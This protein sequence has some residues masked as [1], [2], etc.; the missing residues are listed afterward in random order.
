MFAS[1]SETKHNKE[2]RPGKNILNLIQQTGHLP[3]RNLSTNS[4]NL[5]LHATLTTATLL[6]T[7]QEKMPVNPK[8]KCS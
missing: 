7:L 3:V 2:E 4:L 6:N 5:P 8:I 1:A